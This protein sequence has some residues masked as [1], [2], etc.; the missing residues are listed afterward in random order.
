MAVLQDYYL[1]ATAAKYMAGCQVPIVKSTEKAKGIDSTFVLCPQACRSGFSII[2]AMSSTGSGIGSAP[3]TLAAITTLTYNASNYTTTSN[4]ISNLVHG[5]HPPPSAVDYGFALLSPMQYLATY[6]HRFSLLLLPQL[7]LLPG[8]LITSLPSLGLVNSLVLKMQ[9][10]VRLHQHVCSTTRTLAILH[11]DIGATMTPLPHA[12]RHHE[13]FSPH[14][15]LPCYRII[16]SNYHQIY[17]LVLSILHVAAWTA[18]FS[19]PSSIY[20]G[21]LATLVQP[22]FTLWR[23]M[24]DTYYSF[25]T[26]VNTTQNRSSYYL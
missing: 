19:A 8:S 22:G 2:S 12:S 15:Y 4:S 24:I 21:A 9:L 3:T 5:I 17:L 16:H 11:H 26:H 18:R 14:F 1:T 20:D 10:P 13:M 25:P 7:R 6:I 23:V